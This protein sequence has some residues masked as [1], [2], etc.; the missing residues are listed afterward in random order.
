MTAIS[1]IAGL[2]Q[3]V[4]PSYAFRLVRRFGA[5]RVGWFVVTAFACLAMLHLLAPMKAFRIGTGPDLTLHALL[6]IGSVLLL[7]GMGHLETICKQRDQS[8]DTEF[9]LREESETR[10]K[11]ETLDLAQFNQQLLEEVARLELRGQALG[12]SAA[13]YD[14]LFTENPHP[15]CVIDLRTGEFLA[16]NRAALQ[17]FALASEELAAFT[18][19]DMF[20]PDGADSFDAEIARPCDDAQ[21]RGVWRHLQRDGAIV[22]L[23]ITA[24]DLTSWETPS[25]LL[26]FRDVTGQQRRERKFL[27]IQKMAAISKVSGSVGHHFNTILDTIE[28]NAAGL[29]PKLSDEKALGRVKQI[30]A[31]ASRGVALT[32]QLLAVGGRHTLQ[33]E[34]LD[35]NTLLRNINHLL[36][37]LAGDR[38]IL[39]S[40]YGAFVTPILADPRL[41]EHVIVNLVLN[42]RDAISGNGTISINTTTVRIEKTP[43]DEAA[44]FGEFVRLS[45]RD[46]GSGISPEIQAHLFEPF[47]TTR[48]SSKTMGLGLASIHGIVVQHSG[49]IEFTSEPGDGTEF[50]V[51]LPCAKAYELARQEVRPAAQVAKGTILLVEPDDRARSMAR[52]ALNWQGYR[53]IEADSSSLTLL[54][55]ESQSAQVDLLLIDANLSD[56]ISGLELANQ[57]QQAKP[58]LKIIYSAAASPDE[59]APMHPD[60]CTIVK[61]P[62]AREQLL[63]EVHRSLNGVA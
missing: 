63:D 3:L 13:Q 15:M 11:Q 56:G 50:R 5:Q 32:R 8:L 61:K 18:I 9:K 28:T 45:V 38:I 17:Q 51:F 62:F 27:R 31:A 6:A 40:A 46:T 2:L 30:S 25:R 21:V 39:Q 20:A 42:A 55:W 23:E 24:L 59:E 41:I 44:P 14:F 26:V 57:L 4:V 10:L 22:E 37:R 48:E 12:Q 36:G 34:V 49:W 29:L 43:G 47:F 19:R 16:V 58:E 53:V 54:L 60:N 1:L 35:L 7:I 52:C 33:P